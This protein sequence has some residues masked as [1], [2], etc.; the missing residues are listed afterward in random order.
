MLKV[1][2]VILAQMVSVELAA[3]VALLAQ[4]ALRERPVI[5]VQMA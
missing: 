3:L 2:P 4:L 5:Q 1:R